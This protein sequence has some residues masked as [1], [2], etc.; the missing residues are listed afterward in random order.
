MLEYTKT[1]LVKVAFD[2]ALFRKELKKAVNL[3]ER[4]DAAMLQDWCSSTFGHIHP[5]LVR[6]FCNQ[7]PIC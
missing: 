3:L 4:N 2:K 5:D 7:H 1:I 6:G